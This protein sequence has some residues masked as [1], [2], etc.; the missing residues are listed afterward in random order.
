MEQRARYARSGGVAIAYRVFG[1]GPFDVVY[2]PGVISHV[3]LMTELPTYQG[4]IVEALASFC[5]LI[6]F[7][8]RGIGMSDRMAG[9]PGLETRIDDVRSVMD[10]VGSSRAAIVSASVGVPMSLLFAATY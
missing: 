6:V 7:D 3:E 8:Q 10:S 2:H 4:R 9:T 1:D 5:R